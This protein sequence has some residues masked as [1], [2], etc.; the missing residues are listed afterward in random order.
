MSSIRRRKEVG[1][2]VIQ[3]AGHIVNIEAPLEQGL[4]PAT[5]VD[6]LDA[7]VE[8]A[9]ALHAHLLWQAVFST[10]AKA[11]EV[12][13]RLNWSVEFLSGSLFHFRAKRGK[14]FHT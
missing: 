9:D 8:V 2:S 14:R 13:K 1:V 6:K 3:L 4:D 11:K 7:E 5:A 12:P 10:Q